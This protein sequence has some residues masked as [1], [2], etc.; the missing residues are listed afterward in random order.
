MGLLG[1]LGSGTFF[2]DPAG[3]VTKDTPLDPGDEVGGFFDP[4]N[5]AGRQP[6]LPEFDESKARLENRE[7]LRRRAL[8]G[9]DQVE[10][11]AAPQAQQSEELRRRQLALADQL[12]GVAAGQQAGAGELAA[13]RAFARAQAAQQAGA[14]GV[15][16][17]NAALAQRAASRNLADLGV[18]LAGQ[19]QIAALQDQASARAQLGG[20]LGQTRGQDQ[21]VSLANMNAQLQARGLDDRQRIALMSQLFGI[22]ALELQARLQQEQ[23]QI[24]LT[25]GQQAAAQQQQGNLL[26]AGGGIAGGIF[27]GPA[28]AGAGSAAGGAVGQGQGLGGGISDLGGS[29]VPFGATGQEFPGLGSPL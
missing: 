10:G 13:R 28:G 29:G 7:E 3:L 2:L 15:R 24:A 21:Q 6:D 22:D 25:T 12:G 26:A 19:S 27:G 14:A 17:Q 4:L 5:L 9:L 23:G 20:L 18:G 1:S 11:R 16:G 8:E